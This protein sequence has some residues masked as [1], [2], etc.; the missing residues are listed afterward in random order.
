MKFGKI[1]VALSAFVATG[2]LLPPLSAQAWEPTE[3]IKLVSQSSAGTGNDLLLREVSRI[4][5]KNKMIP[6]S[7]GHE[8]VT[9][10]GGE[11]ARRY[12]SSENAGN[13]YILYAYTPA[14]LNQAIVSKS[15]FT[16][17]KFTPLVNLTNDSGMIAINS[18]SPWKTMA[19]MID[20]AKAKPGSVLQGGG[21]YGG[22]SSLTGKLIAET[23]GVDLPYTPF[24]GGG[25]AIPALLGGHV[26]FV[27]ANTNEVKSYVEAGQMRIL[28]VSEKLEAFPDVPTLKES[29]FDLNIIDWRLVVMPPDV[30]QEVQD[31]YIDLLKRTVETPDWKEYA[32]KNS[33]TSNWKSQEELKQMLTETA[34]RYG[35]LSE[36]MGLMKN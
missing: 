32:A 4:W 26:Q 25:D 6:V 27:V 19:E 20:A 29:G 15:E 14:T 5:V 3:E 18:Q 28:A 13:S 12:V 1:A 23:A 11:N 34:E 22:G 16:Y 9:G 17:D 30:P 21:P 10:A 24:K 36:R 31:Y 33:L 7:V 2:V 8:N 35:A